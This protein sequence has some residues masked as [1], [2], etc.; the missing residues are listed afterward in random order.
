MESNEGGAMY[1]K[2][3]I[4]ECF[5]HKTDEWSQRTANDLNSVHSHVDKLEAEGMSGEDAWGETL[6]LIREQRLA[7]MGK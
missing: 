5:P 3:Q 7:A 1:T 2:Q 6:R 4:A